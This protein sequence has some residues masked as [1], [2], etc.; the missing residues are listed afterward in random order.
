MTIA[1]L[2]QAMASS[3]LPRLAEEP[4]DPVPH[5]FIDRGAVAHGDL[6]HFGQILI[7][8]V[9]QLFGFETVGRLREIGDVR[10]E[11]REFLPLR[12]DS[13]CVRA[14]EDRIIQLGRQ[15][16]GQFGRQ[17]GEE[18][19]LFSQF[20]LCAPELD[21]SDRDD[22]HREQNDQPTEIAM[23]SA[24]KLHCFLHRRNDGQDVHGREIRKIKQTD[25]QQS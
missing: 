25:G 20:D 5:I 7:E 24:H 16:F 15:E 11:D 12:G 6:G 9:R 3:L 13:G 18:L 4:H 8:Q 21:K 1:I 10:E 2:T 19:V 23:E 17:V 14:G 22:D